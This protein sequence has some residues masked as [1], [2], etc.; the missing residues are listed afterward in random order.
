MV[1]RLVVHQFETQ[2]LPGE[3]I[4]AQRRFAAVDERFDNAANTVRLG[5]FTLFDLYGDWRATQDWSL[6]VR[7]NNLTD[8]RYETAYGYNQPGR[9]VYLT[10][11]YT[12]R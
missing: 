5:G 10:V 2:A 6:G 12:P 11:R 9:E 3:A 4:H 1:D 8:R 7:L